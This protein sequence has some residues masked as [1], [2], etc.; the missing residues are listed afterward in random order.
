MQTNGEKMNFLKIFFQGP[1]IN[2]S[3]N[4]LQELSAS[5][6][7]NKAKPKPQQTAQANSKSAGLTP[8]QLAEALSWL[9]RY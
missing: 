1:S 4:D 9:S 2:N 7:S 3:R 5:P 6:D 8:D